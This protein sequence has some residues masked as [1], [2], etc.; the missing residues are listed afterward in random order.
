M[1]DTSNTSRSRIDSLSLRVRQILF[2]LATYLVLLV[3]CLLAVSPEKYDLTVGDVAPKTI[4]AS[5]DTVDEITT[6]RRRKAAADAVFNILPSP[7]FINSV[8]YNF[9]KIY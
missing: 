8:K 1:E 7:F 9:C 3:I 5:K 2:T 6:S 4:T